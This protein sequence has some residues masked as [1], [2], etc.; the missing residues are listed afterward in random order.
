MKGIRIVQIYPNVN[1]NLYKGENSMRAFLQEHNRKSWGE[2][3]VFVFFNKAR[4]ILK[5]FAPESGAICHKR[6]PGKET[7]DLTLRKEQLFNSI[8]WMFGIQWNVR[9]AVYEP[10]KEDKNAEV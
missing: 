10:I 8:G 9:S 2:G 7:W 6:L 3:D 4:N 5:G 1:M